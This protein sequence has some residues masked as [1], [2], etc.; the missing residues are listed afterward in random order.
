MYVYIRSFISSCETCQC[1]KCSTAPPKA[2]LIE[3]F[4]LSAPMQFVS[5]DIAYLPRDNMGYQYILLI[6]DVLSKYIVAIPLKGQTAPVIVDA[7]LQHWIFVHGTPFYILSDQG[8]NDE[9]NVM[10][11]ICTTPTIEKCRSSSYHSQGNS[12]AERNIQSVKDM[13]CAVLLHR[14]LEQSK[15]CSILYNLVFAS[16]T[17]FTKATKCIP[18]EVGFGRTAVLPQDILLGNARD[19]FEHVSASDHL[20]TVSSNLTDIFYQVMHSLA[21]SKTEMQLHYCKTFAL[22]ITVKGNRYC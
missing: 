17:T 5:L 15:W 3:M 7:L 13:L 8:S 18:F 20:H 9:G 11:E 16:N 22:I 1:T 21:L 6:G 2:P 19:R 12:F 14:H 4:S 10:R